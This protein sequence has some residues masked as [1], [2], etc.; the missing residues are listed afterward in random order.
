MTGAFHVLT[1]LVTLAVI[2]TGEA[3]YLESPCP[4]VFTYQVDP[5]TNQIFGYIEVS[6][7][8]IGQAAKLNVDL[9]IGTQLPP[10]NVGSIT[11]VKSREAT[12]NDIVRGL[13]A[14]YRVNFPLQNL[15]P[16]VLSISLNGQTLCSGYRAHGRVITTINLEHMLYTQLQ[17]Q[18]MPPGMNGFGFHRPLVTN[19]VP[20]QPQHHP[21]SNV[22]P[23]TQPQAQPPIQNRPQWNVEPQPTRPQVYPTRPI[24]TRPVLRPQTTTSS[25]AVRTTPAPQSLSSSNR[26]CGKPAKSFLNKLSFNGELTEKGQFPWIVPLFDRTD[27]RDPKYFCGS[28]IITRRHLL[29]SAKCVYYLGELLSPER[30]LAMPGMYNID[31]FFDD[32]A[33]FADIESVIPHEEYVA[34]D[35]LSDSNVA[36]L[37]LK[38]SLEYSNYIIPICAWRGDNDLASIVGEDGVMAGWG[39]T[40]TGSTSVATYIKMTVVDGKQCSENWSRAYPSTARIFC[41]DGHGSTPCIGDA[42]S[43]LV[44][45]RGNQ[46]YL[47]GI[48]SNGQ[49]DSNT[50]KCD[51]TKYAIFIDIAPF[52]FWLKSVTS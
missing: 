5:G 19:S 49:V 52:R 14:Q 34:D 13:P 28:T 39:V 29:T 16:T 33:E 17:P 8:Q 2:S 4:N 42:G 12:F 15:L 43:G 1:L 7:I 18:N 37:R 31:N 40:E 44:L 11:L 20:F 24:V 32:N 45:K 47:R 46:Y 35:D 21:Q 23:Q 50:L 27:R 41:G 10:D 51:V 30:I 36:V 22:V 3:Q 38:K 48:L 26:V 6:N 25:N 9:S